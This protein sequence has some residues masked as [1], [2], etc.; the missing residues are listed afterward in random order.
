MTINVGSKSG[1][2]KALG[3]GIAA[4]VPKPSGSG[5]GLST[6]R[7][8]RLSGIFRKTVRSVFGTEFV[9]SHPRLAFFDP[10]PGRSSACRL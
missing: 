1:D 4:K 2:S 7:F 5:Q 8:Q 6:I 9:G 3:S 10:T